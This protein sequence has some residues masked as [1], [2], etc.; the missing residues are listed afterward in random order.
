MKW[1]VGLVAGLVIAV[2]T[3][4]F[5]WGSPYFMKIYRAMNPESYSE[6]SLIVIGPCGA[7]IAGVIGFIVTVWLFG[8]IGAKK[9]D[10]P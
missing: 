3:F 2:I 9:E 10:E 8:K 5:V 4:N 6:L 1:V 7:I